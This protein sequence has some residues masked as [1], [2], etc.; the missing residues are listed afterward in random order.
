[1]ATR[2]YF[3]HHKTA[4][5]WIGSVLGDLAASLGL[6]SVH[7]AM[8]GCLSL[9]ERIAA[10]DV[11]VI[12]DAYQSEVD[13]L[14]RMRGF[15][16]IRDPRD[17]IVS[18]YFSHRYTHPIN[19]WVALAAHRAELARLSLHDGMLREM[20]FMDQF[21]RQ[22]ASWKYDQPGVLEVRL[23]DLITDPMAQW[24]RIV[25]HLGWLSMDI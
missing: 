21:I 19:G 13:T 11:A 8:R 6:R 7:V 12:A 18:G 14:P 16:V 20:Q 17:M 1:M 23:E 4:T 15:H 3:G 2:A 25:D 5:Q 24:C 9:A 22:L 10:A